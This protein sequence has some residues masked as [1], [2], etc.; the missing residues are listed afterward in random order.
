V[1]YCSLSK[2]KTRRARLEPQTSR[3]G[4]RGI[5]RSAT[6]ASIEDPQGSQYN[7]LK[8]LFNLFL[9]YFLDGESEISLLTFSSALGVIEGKKDSLKKVCITSFSCISSLGDA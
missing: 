6:R 3:S 2:K 8:M 5:K 9:N 1:E 4:V 7:L